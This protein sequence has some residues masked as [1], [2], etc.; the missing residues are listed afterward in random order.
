MIPGSTAKERLESDGAGGPI[1]EGDI[2][3]YGIM[4]ERECVCAC[5]GHGD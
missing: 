2:N 5:V 4:E 3:S 1:C